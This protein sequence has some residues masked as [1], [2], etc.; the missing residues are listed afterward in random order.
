MP[1]VPKVGDVGGKVELHANLRIEV[2]AAATA[3]VPRLLSVEV[4][5]SLSK[6]FYR[7]VSLGTNFVS[8]KH[9]LQFEATPFELIPRTMSAARSAII[10]TGALII[11]PTRSGITDASTTR[12]ASR[13][14][15][16]RSA[17]TTADRSVAGPIL[18][19]PSG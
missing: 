9:E 12:R 1:S 14:W 3:Y 8:S 16:R 15:T 19:V 5:V 10:M 11:P 17:P 7:A 13:P 2:V 18:Q 6:A 4:F